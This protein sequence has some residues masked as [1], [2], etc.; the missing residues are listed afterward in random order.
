M[1]KKR[2]SSRWLWLPVFLAVLAISL[3]AADEKSDRVDKIFAQWDTTASPGC[4]LA[5]VK[6]G[7]IIY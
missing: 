3:L 4:A 7:H 2:L 1:K 6:D 5:V